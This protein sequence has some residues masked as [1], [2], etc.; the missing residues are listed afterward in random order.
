MDAM[1]ARTAA[2]TTGQ[3]NG[4]RPSA[5]ASATRFLSGAGAKRKAES[6][7][8]TW[9]GYRRALV[10]TAHPDDAE[11]MAG[12]TMAH[13]ASLGIEVTLAVATSGDKGTRDVNMRPQ[14]LAAIREQEQ[15]RAAAVLGLARVIFLGYP[16][17][18]LEEGPELR[19]HVVRLIRELQPDIII[20]WDG[21]RAGFN[22]TDHRVIG[23]V[24]R[25]ALYPAAHDPHYHPEHRYRGVGPWR[26]AEALLAA[27]DEPNL[28]VDIGRYL[29]QKVDAI[30]CHESQIEARPR[31][32]WLKGWR[33]RAKAD[34]AR[35]K[36]TGYDFAESFKRIEFRRPPGAP[37]SP[38][39]APAPAEPKSGSKTPARRPAAVSGRRR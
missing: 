22:H 20:T 31:D 1:P 27:T 25:D 14:E 18:F 38:T 9:A 10:I 36:Q 4:R 26:T 28:H 7:D 11:F 16:D 5:R 32:E 8:Q 2:S 21:F 6:L 30:R 34:R 35:R 17:G 24:V 12:G 23:R 33:M 39:G 37:G 29:E 15:R 19:E 13:L 3:T